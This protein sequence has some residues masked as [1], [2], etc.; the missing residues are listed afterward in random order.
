MEN[1]FKFWQKWFWVGIV[2]SI[3]SGPAGIVYGLALIAEPQF[4][5]EG[6]A[7]TVFALLWTI[8]VLSLLV[9]TQ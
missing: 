6:W 5:K 2:I 1:K 7:I 3:L 4:R 8:L 9:Q